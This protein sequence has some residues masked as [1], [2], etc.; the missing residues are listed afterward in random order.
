MLRASTTHASGRDANSRRCWESGGGRICRVAIELVVLR[1]FDIAR[2]K[3]VRQHQINPLRST[4]QS[5]CVIVETSG[6]RSEYYFNCLRSQ[7]DR[8]TPVIR[9]DVIE[10][11]WP[12]YVAE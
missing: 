1:G 8:I 10:S 2:L 3:T 9:T 7:S 6:L 5:F 11:P 12:P 4:Q